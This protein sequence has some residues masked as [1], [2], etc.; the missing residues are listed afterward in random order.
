MEL[1]RNLPGIGALIGL[2]ATLAVPVAD[3]APGR[4]AGVASVSHD[5]EATYSI[6]I[7]LPPG[8]N[9]LTPLL[10]MDYRHRMRGGLLGVGWSLGGLSQIVRCA[11][12][13]AQDGVA[14]PA[15][16]FAEDRFCL[17]GQRLKVVTG[18][19]GAVNAEYRTEVES[20]ARI[21]SVGGSTTLGP[22]SFVVERA[23]GRTYQYGATADSSI[24]GQSTPP[25]GGARTWALNRVRDRADNVIDYKYTESLGNTAFRIA[26]IRY[27][28]N[29]SNGVEASH[30]VVFSYEQRPNA[31][32]DSGY[33]A[34][35]PVRQI[36]RLASIEVRFNGEVLKSYKLDYEAA[37]SSGGR[38]RLS[39]ITECSVSA[40]D[41]FTPTTFEWQDGMDGMSA[42]AAFSGQFPSV[43]PVVAAGAWNLADVNGDGRNDYVFAGGPDR[44][45]A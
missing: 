23:D 3:A 6:L 44:S 28:S 18:S 2:L 24:D 11:R 22:A 9:G 14:E 15:G 35:L 39:R 12:T 27:N 26:S 34:G 17:D 42:V 21:R 45:T 1:Q 32:V 40:T 29:P 13:V 30:E 20:Y 31:E 43:M 16:K 36:V 10:S 5:G 33:V 38:S 4:T 7:D 41:C 8:T 25:A 37:L 19:Y